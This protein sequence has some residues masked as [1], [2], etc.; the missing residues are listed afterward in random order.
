MG[1]RAQ[2]HLNSKKFRF[3]DFSAELNAED[4]SPVF[5]ESLNSQVKTHSLIIWASL[6]NF[7]G[8]T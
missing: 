5:T 1:A 8:K 3:L 7:F 2:S 4:P 6:S